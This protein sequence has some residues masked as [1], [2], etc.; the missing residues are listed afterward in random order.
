MN[1]QAYADD[2][3]I[4]CPS[5][6][7]LQK[8]LN[9]AYSMLSAHGL[10]VNLDKTKIV[11]F[12][13]RFGAGSRVVDFKLGDVNIENVPSVRYLGCLISHNLCDAEDIDRLKANFIKTTGMFYRKFNSIDFNLKLKLFEVLCLNFY[14]SELWYDSF[15]S[16]G[17]RKKFAI[18][19]HVSLKKLLGLPK[20]FSN[21]LVCNSLEFLTFENR[22]NFNVLN[23]YYRLRDCS[24]ICFAA[25]KVYFMRFSN[26][27][28]SINML[29]LLKY[30]IADILV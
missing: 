4:Y 7:G 30:D 10:K 16:N 11:H 8:L 17:A 12:R 1:I 22:M 3:V 9:T 26:M 19:Y 23:F 20:F 21:H 13:K 27:K 18:A 29:S 24:S 25:H 6:S 2:I 5:R 14:G 15:G 28:K